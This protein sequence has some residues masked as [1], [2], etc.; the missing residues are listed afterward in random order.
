MLGRLL[1]AV[2]LSLAIIF[3]ALAPR[4]PL[5]GSL[6]IGHVEVLEAASGLAAIVFLLA[7]YIVY[8]LEEKPRAVALHSIAVMLAF[9][10]YGA[11][12]MALWGTFFRGY[13]VIGGL[14]SFLVA[15]PVIIVAER[16][17]LKRLRKQA[18]PIRVGE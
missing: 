9:L 18:L 17:V 14:A 3:F 15:L 16:A 7:G 12:G 13:G 8:Q 2:G 6:A 10:A 1:I 11:V 5:A 4:S